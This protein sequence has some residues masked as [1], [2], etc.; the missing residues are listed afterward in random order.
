MSSR[1]YLPVIFILLTMACGVFSQTPLPVPSQAAQPVASTAFLPTA[2]PLPTATETITLTPT[3]SETATPPPAT[4]PPFLTSTPGIAATLTVAFSTPGAQETLL[5]QQTMM[6]GTEMVQ[7][8]G[9]SRTLLS[10]C[11]DPSDSPMQTWVDIPVMPQA[12]AGQVVKTLIGSYYCFRAPVTVDQ[13]ETFYKDKLSLPGWVLQSDANGQMVF[14]GLSQAG[15]QYL[16][17][18]S[19]PGNKNDLIVA[20]NV[21]IPLAIP[22]PKQ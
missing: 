11:P 2:T 7:M 4:I 19:A 21:T 9:F 22:T 10:Q 17:L 1:K 13:M 3:P 20:L 16:F 14:V 15:A 18:V 8:Q 12:I 5:A 6:A